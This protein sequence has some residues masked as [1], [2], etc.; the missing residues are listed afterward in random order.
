ME[1]LITGKINGKNYIYVNTPEILE[2]FKKNNVYKKAFFKLLKTHKGFGQDTIDISL[3]FFDEAKKNKRLRFFLIYDKDDIVAISFL[4]YRSNK[5]YIFRV[6][7]NKKYRN[8]GW[9]KRNIKK[10]IQ[11][12]KKYNKIKYFT[13]DANIKHVH[14]IRCYLQSGFSIKKIYKTH[15]KMYIN[16]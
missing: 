16:V 14:A 7:T 4:K 10:I 13:L 12:A 6:H 2:W 15:Y 8:M 1:E 11:L 3:L 5:A 9:C